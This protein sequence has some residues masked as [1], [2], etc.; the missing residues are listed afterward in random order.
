MY[1]RP[2]D[3]LIEKV[4]K[5]GLC[6]RCGT[7]AGACPQ[8]TITFED[9]TGDCLPRAGENCSSCSSCLAVCPGAYQ[10]FEFF[11]RKLFGATP[12]NELLGAVR[13]A[14]LAHAADPKTRYRA[15]SGGVVTALLLDCLGRAEIDGAVVFAP[16]EKEPWRGWGKIARGESDILRAAQSRYHLSPMN[17]VLAELRESSDRLAYAGIPCQVHG[18]RNL[19]RS[20][21][22]PKGSIEIVIGIYCGNNLYYE[23]T[24]AMMRKLG[25][26]DTKDVEFLAY[27]EGKW[28]GSFFVRTKDGLERSISKLHFNQAIPFYINRRC[29][30]CIDLSNELADISVGDGWAKEGSVEGWSVVLVR[31]EKGE[32]LFDGA[33]ERGSLVAER[34]SLDDALR[35]HAHALDLKKSGS[36]LRLSLWSK[37]GCSV[38]RYDRPFRGAS[39]GRRL[40]ELFVSSQFALASSSAGRAF[41]RILPTMATG[42][43]FSA[44][45]RLWIRIASG[46]R[47][48]A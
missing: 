15:A 23:G 16:H 33:L 1:A 9:P 6:T 22:K 17:T 2:V 20:G 46:S 11:E 12:R 13:S 14:W 3:E 7:C 44:L 27:R 42:K 36:F 31:S 28:P 47:L 45:R 34:I 25:V 4:V 10:E 19:E 5:K 40:M 18:L 26:R 21:W 8:G 39:K 32:M 43:L 24:L 30:F 37:F 41:F 48:K 35:M 38:P 29:L